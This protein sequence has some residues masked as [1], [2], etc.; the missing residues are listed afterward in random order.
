MAGYS[1]IYVVGGLGGHDGCDGVNPIE[2]MLLVGNADRQWLEPRYMD[3]ATKPL[4]RLR[5]VVPEGPDH[6]DALL[7]ACIAF[8]PRYFA[9]CPSLA[10]VAAELRD[11]ERLDLHMPI[12]PIPAAWAVLREEARA[13]FARLNIWDGELTRLRRQ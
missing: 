3:A 4:G 1:R 2:F 12:G 6:A 9:E 10:K 13:P 5:F 11:V 7:D 8:A